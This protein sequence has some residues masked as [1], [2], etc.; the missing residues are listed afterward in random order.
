MRGSLTELVLSSRASTAPPWLADSPRASA[1]ARDKKQTVQ[2]CPQKEER[3]TPDGDP[4]RDAHGT[5]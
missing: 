4:T 5:N 1:G 2:S 3:K